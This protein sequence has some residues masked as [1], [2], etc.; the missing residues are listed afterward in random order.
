MTGKESSPG[1]LS[2]CQRLGVAA[3]TIYLGC[4][5]ST[6]VPGSHPFVLA[7]LLQR[8]ERVPAVSGEGH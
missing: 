4:G 2:G 3:Y 8:P 7:G 6:V 5:T 1:S